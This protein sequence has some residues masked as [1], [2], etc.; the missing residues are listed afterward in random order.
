MAAVRSTVCMFKQKKLRRKEQIL[1]SQCIVPGEEGLKHMLDILT[2]IDEGV[3]CLHVYLETGHCVNCKAKMGQADGQT[4]RHE[5][6]QHN[7]QNQMHR[8]KVEIVIFNIR[9]Y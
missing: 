2:R 7:N 1:Y 9:P 3:R 5:H 6:D 4:D 8:H